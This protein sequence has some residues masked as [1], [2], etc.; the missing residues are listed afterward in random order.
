MKHTKEQQ[1]FGLYLRIP[2][3]HI[4]SPLKIRINKEMYKACYYFDINNKEFVINKIVVLDKR[5]NVV[6][7]KP[8]PKMFYTI[9]KPDKKINWIRNGISYMKTLYFLFCARYD[10]R[11]YIIDKLRNRYEE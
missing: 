7:Y 8:N 10:V 11:C 3:E 6:M 1:I 5:Y 4:S 2:G 9:M